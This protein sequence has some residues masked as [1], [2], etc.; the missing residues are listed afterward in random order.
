MS[1]IQTNIK[2]IR[3][4]LE[5]TQE[6]VADA[7]G[8]ARSTYAEYETTDK[9]IPIETLEKL[10]D[11]F[12]VEIATFFAEDIKHLDDSLVCAFRMDNACADD[13]QKITRFKSI[14]KNYIK[15]KKIEG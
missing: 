14:V 11:F 13:L 3:N 9:D 12:G 5:Y 1:T 6:A 10:S 8:I 2:E 7:L 4:K 15:M